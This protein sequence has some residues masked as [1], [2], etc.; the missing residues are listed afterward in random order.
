[1]TFRHARA[2]LLDL[3]FLWSFAN[4]SVV[5]AACR[6]IVSARHDLI[7]RP[8]S[9]IAIKLPINSSAAYGEGP[10]HS[11][12]IWDVPAGHVVARYGVAPI[13][14][15]ADDV[16]KICSAIIDGRRAA[17]YRMVHSGADELAAV[18][19][20]GALGP[21]LTITVSLANRDHYVTELVEL[22]SVTFINDPARLRL[23]SIN[24]GDNEPSLVFSNEIGMSS[25]FRI[26][27]YVSK[28]T[29]VVWEIAND[30][31]VT[32][33]VNEQKQSI[34]HWFSISP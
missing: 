3:T 17:I 1:M 34:L 5:H 27:D 20:Q 22:S 21:D 16:E 14:W 24:A 11:S 19:P 28:R 30:F 8:S 23:V 2:L 4:A 31:V 33:S 13:S 6:E 18:F 29:G 26:G 9:D 32:K 7:W 10:G 25:D 12:V 15:W